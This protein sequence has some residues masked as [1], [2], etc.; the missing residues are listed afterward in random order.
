MG[1]SSIGSAV[2]AARRHFL[3]Q[4][5]VTGAGVAVSSA[6][7][8]FVPRS[9]ANGGR[10]QTP[11]GVQVGDV[12]NDRAVIWSRADR[13]ARMWLEVATTES[14]RN[15]VRLRGPAALPES[16]FTAKF[17]LQG[18]PHGERI[19]CRVS[20]EAL[21]GA[22]GTSEPLLC[23]FQMPALRRRDV[24]FLWS[25]DVCGQGWGINPD[26][27][28]MRI[29]ETMRQLRPDFFI[30]SGD[31]IYADGP[32][33]ETVTLADGGI[34][35]N[36]TTEAKAKVAETQAEYHGQYA[37]NLLDENLRRFNAEVPIYAQ[38]DDHEVVNN[39][40]PGEI[41]ADPR[42]S[43]SQVDLLAA[44][45]ERAFIDYM[46]VRY[47]PR[48]RLYQHF[49]YGRSLEIFRIDLRSFRGPNTAN[50]QPRQGEETAFLG[51]EQLAWLKEALA[52]STATWKIIASDMPIG[53]IVADGPTAF[54]NGANGNDGPALGRE[55]ELAE[56]LRFIRRR[57][58]HNVVWLTADVHYTAAHYYDP[59]QAS[60]GDFDPF[61]EFVSG[62]L[63]AGTFGPGLLD[64]TFGPQLK[65]V[66]APPPGQANLPPSAGLQFFGQVDLDGASETL[67]VTLK[68]L[69]GAALFTQVLE[70]VH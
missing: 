46:P 25:G 41:L 63:N 38:W 22:V 21:D 36:L 69:N 4:M 39:W 57:R 66:K 27:G 20:F 19:F 8:G 35:R 14:F 26:L 70:P 13:P 50:T 62:P 48:T 43:V 67:T 60:T 51:S 56:L 65:Y 29:F 64:K 18:L 10:V 1:K 17:Y 12:L 44:R 58:I 40:Y 42:Y 7:P 47:E 6:L 45:A 49:R 34:W 55:L 32:L 37:Y 59:N 3:R 23:Q 9:W 53:L 52:R 31:S 33:V 24:R 68:D 61:W 2:D 30:H 5:A 54:E 28:G 11:S 16:D 15:A